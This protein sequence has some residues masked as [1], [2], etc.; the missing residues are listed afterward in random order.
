MVLL[1]R[2]KKMTER[3]GCF[4]LP[5]E[6]KLVLDGSC[7]RLVY[8]YALLLKES[9]EQDAGL[10]CRITR[11]C[12]SGAF[13]EELRTGTGAK[14]GR[15]ED[16]TV[17]LENTA[18]G[19]RR[20]VPDTIRLLEDASLEEQQYRLEIAEQ[21]V[22]IAGGA[23]AGILWGI[24]TLRQILRQ[25]GALL[26][27]LLIEDAPDLAVRGFYHD[28]TR[29]RIPKLSY[30]KK[31]ADLLSYYKI[32]QLQLYIEQSYLFEGLSELWRD[33]TP[34]TAEDILELDRYCVARGVELVPSLSTFG[35]LYK[36]LQTKQYRGLCELE[37]AGQTPF[38]LKDRMA[39]HTLDVRNEEAIRL[40]RSLVQEYLPLF[41]SRKFNLCADETFD[42]GR[43]KNQKYAEQEGVGRLYM[44]YVKSLCSFV[45]EQGSTPMFWGDVLLG[46]PELA[47]EL[48]EGTICLNWG[49]DPAQSEDSTRTYAEIGVRQYVCSGVTGWNQFV[50]QQRDSYENI[51]RM[52]RYAQ[53]Y[54]CEGL[55][56]TDWGDLGH[57]NHPQHS[58][59][60]LIYGAAASWNRDAFP[61]YETLNREISLL[62]YE[63]ADGSLMETTG[64][65]ARQ[66]SFSWYDA[67][68]LKERW[69]CGGASRVRKELEARS[70]TIRTAAQREAEIADCVRALKGATRSMPSGKRK[71]VYSY[72]V[73]ADGIRLINRIGEQLL[74]IFTQ[75]EEQE[76]E[77]I[78]KQRK[79]LGTLPAH[80]PQSAKD[81][82]LW[83]TAEELERWYY[84]YCEL[85]REVS[86]ESELYRVGEVIFW[87]ADLLRTV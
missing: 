68:I 52:S 64:R 33:D 49:Y 82:E 53:K 5:N 78:L 30:L 75:R 38:A 55:L 65:L 41:S 18:Q 34:L 79:E 25:E 26:P 73:A 35:H 27:C 80:R 84:A 81:A 24:Q 77:Q 61:D 40:I 12:G 10:R 32:N 56:N 23:S 67:V 62:Q 42:L 4:A 36:L 57:I 47:N 66:V 13:A 14:A 17:Q 39:H 48:P 58:I 71:E 76:L 6:V 22:R 44:D 19:G 11:A 15:K 20:I 51:S 50:N 7:E 9:V 21:G 87:Y 85:W 63:D 74:R 45:L 59:P 43:G 3:E 54:G 69:S 2:P 1:P 83:E 46:F 8:E 16:G 29:G 28:V 60:G 31:L 72:L 37:N 86:R 70:E